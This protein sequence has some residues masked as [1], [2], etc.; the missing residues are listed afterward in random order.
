MT[1][2]RQTIAGWDGISASGRPNE[3]ERLEYVVLE[4]ETGLQAQV[5]KRGSSSLIGLRQARDGPRLPGAGIEPGP[6]S[7]ESPLWHVLPC[8]A[9]SSCVDV[10]AGSA[11][12]ADD[13]LKLVEESEAA[14]G[15]EV[16]AAL[17]DAA[18][19]SAE[20]RRQFV[21]A[22]RTLIAKVPG[23]CENAPYF[24]K[25]KFQIDLEAKTCTCPAGQVTSR[26]V[27][28]GSGASRRGARP[29]HMAFAFDAKVCGQCPLRS[30]CDTRRRTRQT[31][32]RRTERS[33]L[34]DTKSPGG[35]TAD[36]GVAVREAP[37]WGMR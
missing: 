27:R 3:F 4:R 8:H 2:H 25:D 33:R 14:T 19:G 21:D 28:H 6:H 37:A 11:Q 34:T 12:D 13:A 5:A 30:Q 7:P 29:P 1:E 31:P 15:V 26:V 32:G 23:N 16:E 9:S 35:R 20:T 36:L 22:N 17:G 10:R 24:T 18:Y